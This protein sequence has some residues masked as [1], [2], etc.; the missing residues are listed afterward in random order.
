MGLFYY[1]LLDA[2]VRDDIEAV[3]VNLARE[4]FSSDELSYIC[5]KTCSYKTKEILLSQANTEED[6]KAL[7]FALVKYQ[8]VD[9]AI[10]LLKNDWIVL[11]EADK[12]EV[13]F[14]AKSSRCFDGVKYLVLEN[15][16]DVSSNNKAGKC[17]L[18]GLEGDYT[19]RYHK[20]PY[21]QCNSENNAGAKIDIF[22][23][24]HGALQN[25]ENIAVVESALRDFIVYAGETKESPTLFV[26]ELCQVIIKYINHYEGET[27]PLGL[28][29]LAICCAL[30]LKDNALLERFI[31]KSSAEEYQWIERFLQSL[32]HSRVSREIEDSRHIRHAKVQY[33]WVYESIAGL[34]QDTARCIDILGGLETTLAEQYR[35]AGIDVSLYLRQSEPFI[36]FN[37]PWPVLKSVS[38]HVKTFH[39]LNKILLEKEQ[40]H[41]INQDPDA[42]VFFSGFVPA[43]IASQYVKEG[44]IFSEYNY[45]GNLLHGKY[46]HR[47]Q[48][49]IIL[50]AIEQG[51]INTNG[52]S[53]KELLCESTEVWTYL[54]D[55]YQALRVDNRTVGFRSPFYLHA[56]LLLL[57]DK[58]PCL[59]GTLR[60]IY[61]RSIEIVSRYQ[62]QD[63]PFEKICAEYDI[64][65]GSFLNVYDDGIPSEEYYRSKQKQDSIRVVYRGTD[66]KR[67]ASVFFKKQRVET[68]ENVEDS[69][70][71][72]DHT[73]Q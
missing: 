22:L 31:Q 37:L 12:I 42:P 23:I 2:V 10:S 60:K 50:T 36:F 8:E 13:L 11:Q 53:S 44:N 59:S 21:G 17:V 51:L 33:N 1:D 27:L 52:L 16:V 24:Q 57:K 39:I 30:V 5:T 46:S 66:K 72:L 25:P 47:L 64:R 56:S 49:Y 55:R 9:F 54:L 67:Y 26:E 61:S 15:D 71:H 41:G 73:Y 3:V 14:A 58:L 35:A 65:E 38:R 63:M 69:A 18:D 28:K 43:D 19:L 32:V 68:Q 34:L 45:I 4:K 62:T 48:W 70:Q 20:G 6:R 7:F 29:R 40:K